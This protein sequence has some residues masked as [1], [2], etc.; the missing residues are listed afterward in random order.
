MPKKEEEQKEEVKK[1]KPKKEKR[2]QKERP[3]SKKKHAKVQVW[4]LYDLKNGLARKSESCPRCGTGTFLATYKN[5]K[6][7]GKCGWS[8]TTIEEKAQ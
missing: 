4:K 2:S 7:C 3:R 5:R 1:E 8:Q 6:Y